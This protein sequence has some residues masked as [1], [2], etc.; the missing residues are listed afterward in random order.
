MTSLIEKLQ[1]EFKNAR[2]NIVNNENKRSNSD[3]ISK[4]P[5]LITSYYECSGTPEYENGNLIL[6]S[7]CPFNN[8]PKI[9]EDIL[10]NIESL[11]A[12][13]PLI[14]SI[15]RED[16]IKQ[17]LNIFYYNSSYRDKILVPIPYT[18]FEVALPSLGIA[19]NPKFN[20]IR[21]DMLQY[22][23]K[24][25]NMI[26]AKYRYDKIYITSAYRSPEYHALTG[27]V[28]FDSHIIGCAVDIQCDGELKKDIERY[29][30]TIGFGGI[31]IGENF[32]HLDLNGKSKWYY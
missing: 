12:Q 3:V 8:I 17:W 5:L 10:E 31:G 13:Y 26:Y 20:C 18:K 21:V 30:E 27:C 25:Y 2:F 6:S 19:K 4:D 7:L 1:L 14:P 22:L 32:I 16:Y 28:D 15:P 29:A 11:K 23:E 9:D 24:L